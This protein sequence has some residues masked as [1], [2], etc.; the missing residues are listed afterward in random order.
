VD[1]IPK[2]TIIALGDAS[3]TSRFGHVESTPNKGMEKLLRANFTVYDVDEYNTWHNTRE[4]TY[5]ITRVQYATL[6]LIA[7]TNLDEIKEKIKRCFIL[8]SG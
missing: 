7:I 1:S 2:G 5:L 6:L 8:V 3:V 4:G